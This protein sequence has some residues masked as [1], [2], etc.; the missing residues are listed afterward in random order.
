MTGTIL[1]YTPESEVESEKYK[2]KCKTNNKVIISGRKYNIL[3]LH[4]HSYTQFHS[5]EQN[6]KHF[7]A[8][9]DL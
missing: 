5:L 7:C 6:T 4:H 3:Q 8:L 2:G 1:N 9:P